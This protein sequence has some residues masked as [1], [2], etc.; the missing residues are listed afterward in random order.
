MIGNQAG[1]AEL[2]MALKTNSIVAENTL[3]ITLG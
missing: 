1:S 3:V 2:G